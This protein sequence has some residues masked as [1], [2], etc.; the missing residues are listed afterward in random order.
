[1]SPILGLMFGLSIGIA[2]GL[3][4]GCQHGRAGFSKRLLQTL[5]KRSYRILSAAGEAIDAAALLEEVAKAEDD[6]EF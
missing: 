3:V 5:N 6:A 1:M 2:C 4:A